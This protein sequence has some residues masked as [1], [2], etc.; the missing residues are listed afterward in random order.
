M[1]QNYTCGSPASI[2]DSC[3]DRDGE[4]LGN[5]VGQ[6]TPS[7]NTSTMKLWLRPSLKIWVHIR[8][9][10]IPLYSIIFVEITQVHCLARLYPESSVNEP[11]HLYAQ[12]VGVRA[13]TLV[14]HPAKEAVSLL[15]RQPSLGDVARKHT[16][17]ADHRDS[18]TPGF[19]SGL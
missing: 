17:G 15:Q 6:S 8:V 4:E 14:Y 10:T 16:V 12:V 3:L 9:F 18:P 13:K 11:L 5:N 2:G 19:V 1:R 7:T